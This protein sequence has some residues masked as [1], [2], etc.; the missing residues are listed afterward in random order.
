MCSSDLG[1]ALNLKWM[2]E[3]WQRQSWYRR[4]GLKLAFWDEAWM[5]V[6]G[7]L[8]IKRPLF[9][10]NY[11]TGVLYREFASLEDVHQSRR[12]IENIM[13]L[14]ALLDRMDLCGH[15]IGKTRG[16]TWKSLLLTLWARECT[17]GG[18]TQL[19]IGIGALGE[20]L[21]VLKTARG[22]ISTAGRRNFLQWLAKRSR[23]PA[24]AVSEVLAAVFEALF[25]ELEAE[26]GR[27]DTRRLDKRLVR[28]FLVV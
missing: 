25:Q 12:A 20:F 19:T 9:F 8:L 7:G 23:Q 17:G 21:A 15:P 26:Y 4:Q 18:G 1:A 2:A 14:D 3:N 5:G 24:E 13:A 28:L 22:R 27:V 16:L 11:S 10:D 6:L